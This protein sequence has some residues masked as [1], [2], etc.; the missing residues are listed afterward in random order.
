MD[1]GSWTWCVWLRLEKCCH[2]GL[3]LEEN[4]PRWIYFILLLIACCIWRVC[5][6]QVKKSLLFPQYQIYSK[7]SSTHLSIYLLTYLSTLFY[8][9]IVDLIWKVSTYCFLFLIGH[10]KQTVLSSLTKLMQKT[11]TQDKMDDIVMNIR[12]L[13]RLKPREENEPIPMNVSVYT[14]GSF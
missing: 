5:W 2:I 8:V 11:N 12:R 4:R 10:I 9:M 6:R 14:Q 13:T 3:Q 1:T 7:I